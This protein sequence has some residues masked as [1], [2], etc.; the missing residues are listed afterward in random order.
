MYLKCG[1]SWQVGSLLASEKET[2]SMS[3]PRH[4]NSSQQVIVKVVT[5]RHKGI[6]KE[7][8]EVPELEWTL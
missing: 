6:S 5:L 7:Y 3:C 2:K 4:D 1:C 8:E